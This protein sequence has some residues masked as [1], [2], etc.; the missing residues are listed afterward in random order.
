MS[1]NNRNRKDKEG[2]QKLTNETKYYGD[3]RD[4]EQQCI[5]NYS[6]EK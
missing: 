6:T 1:S 2:P 4:M 5:N 3:I